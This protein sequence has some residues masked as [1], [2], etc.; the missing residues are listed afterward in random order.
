MLAGIPF[1]IVE[2]EDVHHRITDEDGLIRIC[3]DHAATVVVREL[4]NQMGGRWVVTTPYGEA[5]ILGC[6]GRDLWIGNARVGIPKT[7]TGGHGHLGRGR[8]GAEGHAR[9][10]GPIRF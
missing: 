3:F 6:A 8:L 7:G 2:G 1:D 10:Q 9:T 4:P 5:Q